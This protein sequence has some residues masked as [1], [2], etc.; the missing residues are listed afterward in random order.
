MRRDLA[1]IN[2]ETPSTDDGKFLMSSL[3]LASQ[4]VDD[5]GIRRYLSF[6]FWNCAPFAL[7]Q[8]VLPPIEKKRPRAKK[9]S[10]VR[11]DACGTSGIYNSF[12]LGLR[13]LHDHDLLYGTPL[14]E[15]HRETA[16]LVGAR[17]ALP[18]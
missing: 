16:Q 3:V 17:G 6:T 5:S 7:H 11:E 15:L 13:P 12:L 9:M 2:D 18:G 4:P 10:K 8:A 14:E 1:F